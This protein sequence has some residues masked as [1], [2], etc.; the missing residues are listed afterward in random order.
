MPVRIPPQSEDMNNTIIAYALHTKQH[1]LFVNGKDQ[2]GANG[3]GNSRLYRNGRRLWGLSWHPRGADKVL[4]IDHASLSNSAVNCVCHDNLKNPTLYFSA[5][6]KKDCW[7]VWLTCNNPGQ[8]PMILWTLFNSV[9]AASRQLGSKVCLSRDAK[10]PTSIVGTFWQ[11][12][13]VLL[14]TVTHVLLSR[15]AV[16]SDKYSGRF[17][18]FPLSSS[19]QPMN[20]DPVQSQ[21]KWQALSRPLRWYSVF[22][23]FANFNEK[24]TKFFTATKNS[25]QNKPRYFMLTAQKKS[26]YSAK[27]HIETFFVR[28][29]SLLAQNWKCLWEISRHVRCLKEKIST[30]NLS[31][32]G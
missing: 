28:N 12:V 9:S 19:V 7:Q 24:C 25:K 3:W 26:E 18:Q 15:W 10:V 30:D 2:L 22:R 21:S 14:W 32:S 31:V 6:V 13:T 5:N 11:K 1:Y 27:S 17:L 16:W 23:V 4:E 29:C 20:P 8:N